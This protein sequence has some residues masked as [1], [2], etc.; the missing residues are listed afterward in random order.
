M[1][2]EY[3]NRNIQKFIPHSITGW[4]T[5]FVVILVAFSIGKMTSGSSDSAEVGNHNH[6]ANAEPSVWTCS[7]HPQ[8]K[9][10]KAGKCPICFMDLI[11]LTT[12]SGDELEPSQIRISETAKKLAQIQS[13]PVTRTFAEAEI[14]MVGKIAYDETN[15]NYISAWVPGRLDRLYA[16]Y[17][18]MQVNKGDHLVSIYSPDLLSA[19][20]ELI[21]SSIAISKLKDSKSK[22]LTSTAEQTLT[23]TK[24]KLRLFGLSDAQ[25]SNIEQSGV[26]SDHLTINAPIGGVIVNKNATEGMY[27]KTGTQIYTISDLTKLWIYFEAYESDLP[28]I[29]YGQHVEF[30][31]TSFPGKTFEAIISFIDPVVDTKKR[32]VKVRA[33][34]DNADNSLKP[35]MF[36]TGVVKS[37]LDNGGNVVDKNLAGKWISPMHPEIIKNAPGTCDVCGMPL[38]PAKELGYSTKIISDQDTPLLI[39]VTAPLVTGKRAVVYIELPSDDEGVIFEGREVVLGPRAGDFYIVKSGL[40]EGDM[41]VVNGAFKIDSELQI[42]AKP[43]M[44]SPQTTTTTSELNKNEFPMKMKSE[45]TSPNNNSNSSISKK[46]LNALTPLYNNYFAVQMALA[47]DDNKATIQSFK[48]SLNALDKIDMNLFEGDAHLTWMKFSGDISKALIEGIESDTISQSRTAFLHLSQAII[49][50]HDIFGHQ[51]SKNY[52]LTYCPMAFDNKGAHWLQTVDTVYNSFY[53]DMM[54]RCGEIQKTY[55]SKS[56]TGK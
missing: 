4:I 43:S 32:T 7:M 5:A 35:D 26:A 16:D 23:A 17:T 18:G 24:E 1:N 49:S 11:P 19:Q 10:S 12:S 13:K 30:T 34:V 2:N 8:I 46:A 42:Q 53:G 29:R 37:K 3:K 40:K 47:N 36:V 31:S 20:E 38:V 51:D 50:L 6:S 15:L 44:M 22:I 9:L 54:L 28:W 41:V 55:E 21:Q 45:A 14:R 56:G 48:N 27:V 33:I 25:I 39:P 52:Y